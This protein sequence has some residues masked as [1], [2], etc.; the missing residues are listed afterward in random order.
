MH[1]AHINFVPTAAHNDLVVCLICWIH[2]AVNLVAKEMPRNQHSDFFTIDEIIRGSVANLRSEKSAA[3]SSCLAVSNAN[4]TFDPTVFLTDKSF[5][6]LSSELNGHYM[7]PAA[8]AKRFSV[9]AD[10]NE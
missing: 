1:F 3:S 10:N 8:L 6:F 7:V 5:H 2:L 4:I 9:S